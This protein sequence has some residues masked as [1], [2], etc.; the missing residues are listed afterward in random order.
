MA[1]SRA[2]ESYEVLRG[3]GHPSYM[4]IAT[5]HDPLVTESPKLIQAFVN[6]LAAASHYTRQNRGEAVEIFA[7][8][9]PNV[10]LEVARKAIRHINYDPRMSRESVRAFENAQ[11][12][13]L[14]LTIKNAQPLR[15]TDVVLTAYTAAAQQAQPGYFSDLPALPR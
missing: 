15:I 6:G 4:M 2:P 10:N 5:V 8:W 1:M 3:G 9:V 11:N 14:K 7:K 13:L 12:D